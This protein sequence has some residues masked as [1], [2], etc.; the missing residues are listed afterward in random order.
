LNVLYLMPWGQFYETV[1]A[2]MYGKP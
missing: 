1:L 2:E